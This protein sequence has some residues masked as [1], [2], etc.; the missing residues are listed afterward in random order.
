MSI[1]NGAP[2]PPQ[3][4]LPHVSGFLEGLFWE[5]SWGG[6]LICFFF[7]AGH[8]GRCSF[9][10]RQGNREFILSFAAR[11][12]KILFFHTRRQGKKT[13]GYLSVPAAGPCGPNSLLDRHEVGVHDRKPPWSLTAPPEPACLNCG[14]KYPGKHLLEGVTQHL[15]KLQVQKSLNREE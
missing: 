7:S 5:V 15:T 9:F 4:P 13:Q 3:V 10:H 8:K 11:K 12:R 14:P 6:G 2:S 1:W